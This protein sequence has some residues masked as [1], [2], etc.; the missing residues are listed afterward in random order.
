MDTKLKFEKAIIQGNLNLVRELVYTGGVQVTKRHVKI[1]KTLKEL[2]ESSSRINTIYDQVG[3]F[4][5]Q[6]YRPE[7]PKL[8]WLQR[9]IGIDVFQL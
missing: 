6:E 2:C 4:L 1:A 5:I 7:P 8:N 9:L 3:D